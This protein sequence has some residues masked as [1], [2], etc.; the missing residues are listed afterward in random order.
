VGSHHRRPAAAA[1]TN[2]GGGQPGGGAFGDQVAFELGQGGK[3]MEDKLPPGGG[4]IDGLLEAA[5][6][7][8]AIGQ[9]GVD[10]VP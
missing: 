8:P 2:P 9:T 1:A 7:D 3:D 6:P 4:G 5:E 10:Q